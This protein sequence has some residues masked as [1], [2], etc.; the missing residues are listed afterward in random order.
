M[1]FLDVE[2][3]QAEAATCAVCNTYNRSI[4]DDTE[5]QNRLHVFLGTIVLGNK[6]DGEPRHHFP[7]VTTMRSLPELLIP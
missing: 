2:G 3:K 5:L 1:S 4:S 7:G 6:N